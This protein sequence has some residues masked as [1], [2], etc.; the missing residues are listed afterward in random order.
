MLHVI[1]EHVR[2]LEDVVGE[3][4]IRA[5]ASRKQG[6]EL[7]GGDLPRPPMRGLEDS[8]DARHHRL[9]CEHPVACPLE[10]RHPGHVAKHRAVGPVGA[11]GDNG[12]QPE[13]ERLQLAEAA[14]VLQH[15]DGFELDIVRDQKLLG[16]QAAG[17]TRLPVNLQ[18]LS[19]LICRHAHS[20]PEP[21]VCN[22]PPRFNQNCA[23]LPQ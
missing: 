13:A 4:A 2:N 14:L 19:R 20:L 22:R 21:N 16:L 6:V 1:Q 18:G 5:R 10:A 17:A 23:V 12:H 7:G 9:R 3:L 11:A 8:V 15:V